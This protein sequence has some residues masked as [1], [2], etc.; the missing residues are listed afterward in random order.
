MEKNIDSIKSQIPDD[1]LFGEIN[2]AHSEFESGNIKSTCEILENK[3]LEIGKFS[4]FAG[5][6]LLRQKS[7]YYFIT[8]EREK[9]LDTL[10]KLG[11]LY[12]RAGE[13]ENAI[14]AFSTA[15]SLD[16]SDIDLK[17]QIASCVIESGDIPVGVA[18]LKSVVEEKKDYYEA[19]QLLLKS[20]KKYR[21]ESV[22]SYIPEHLGENP[23]DISAHR[24]AIDIYEELGSKNN[25]IDIRANLIKLLDG[26]DGLDSFV[27]E[28]ARLYPGET[29]FLLEKF[30][31]ALSSSNMTL[32]N[33]SLAELA[34]LQE[35]KGLLKET[36]Y[37]TELQLLLDTNSERLLSRVKNLRERLDYKTSPLE[38]KQLSQDFSK[39]LK[40]NELLKLDFGKVINAITAEISG[41]LTENIS[42]SKSLRSILLDKIRLRQSINDE[43][44]GKSSTPVELWAS[45]RALGKSPTKLHEL[46]NEYPNSKPVLEALLKSL[47]TEEERIELWLKIA[48]TA[49]KNNKLTKIESILRL[50]A[51]SVNSLG[52]Y[53]PQIE[54]LLPESHR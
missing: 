46:F 51:H 20:S 53:I 44:E 1:V 23:K 43:F 32:V 19:I 12:R 16:I 41:N 11:T 48:T 49:K 24:Y 4:S 37:Y 34:D 27:M 9:C 29:Q 26:E 35:R 2:K 6:S 17:F 30:K 18:K 54:S 14:K 7:G 8:G 50:L 52:K 13:Y 33:E 22:T 42:H 36:L 25:A 47:P 3:D 10:R 39:T 31:L 5:I 45:L 40:V 28:C 21:P 38:H 15:R